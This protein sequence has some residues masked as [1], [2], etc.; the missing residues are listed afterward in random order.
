MSTLSPRQNPPLNVTEVPR[1][2]GR[3]PPRKKG[4]PFRAG[5]RSSRESLWSGEMLKL[6]CCLFCTS[7]DAMTTVRLVVAER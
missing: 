7:S 1:Q 4:Q 6:S 5:P 3:R 2:M